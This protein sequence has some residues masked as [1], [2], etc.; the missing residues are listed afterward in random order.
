MTNIDAGIKLDA[1]SF[2]NIAIG[3]NAARNLETGSRNIFIGAGA[4]RSLVRGDDNLIIGDGIDVPD[5]YTSN[6]VN[7]LDLLVFEDGRLV[8]N[9]LEAPLRDTIN[10]AI[11]VAYG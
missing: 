4:G 9:A 2:N 1:H 6:Y 10:R 3:L 8:K 7:I 5:P 11:G